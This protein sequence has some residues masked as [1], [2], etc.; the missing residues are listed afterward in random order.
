MK[1]VSIS[2]IKDMCKRFV[3]NFLFE[4][5]SSLLYDLS[6]TKNWKE[7]KDKLEEVILKILKTLKFVWCNPVFHSEF[8]DTMKIAKEIL[9]EELIIEYHPPF[10]NGLELDTFF[11]KYQIALEV[12]GNQHRFHNTGWYKDVKKLED[13]VNRDRRK[14]CICQNNG[15]FLLEIF[16]YIDKSVESLMP[17]KKEDVA[18]ISLSNYKLD[19]IIREAIHERYNAEIIGKDLFIKYDGYYKEE[20]HYQLTNSARTHNPNW[21]VN[22]NVTCVVGG[23]NFRPN[24]GIWFRKPTFAQGTNL[25]A[26]LCPPPNVW[27]EVFYNRD[28]DRSHALSKIDNI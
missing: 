15:I 17:E 21:G 4:N 1:P 3:S 22:S 20:I 16:T 7:S 12:Q 8:I 19:N 23:N 10:L 18:K 9:N 25:I 5:L 14:G 6:H 11:Q 26:N 27:I 24:V 13:I 28:S 2:K